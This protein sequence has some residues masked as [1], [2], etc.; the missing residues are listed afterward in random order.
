[1]TDFAPPPYVPPA[2]DANNN[3][4]PDI[5]EID[6]PAG[7]EAKMTPEGRPY[8][9]NH[10]TQSSTWED[11]RA[12]APPA[13]SADPNA[14][15]DGNGIPDR[16][17]TNLPEGWECRMQGNRPYWLNHNSHV[18]QW[19]D[20]RLNPLAGVVNNHTAA[21]FETSG[22]D[23]MPGGEAAGYQQKR[24]PEPISYNNNASAGGW[25]RQATQFTND[26][27]NYNW[28]LIAKW[29]C[30]A[31]G[32]ITLIVILIVNY[33]GSSNNNTSSR[34]SSRSSSRSSRGRRL[35]GIY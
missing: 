6:L 11:P 15:L 28:V 17:E 29:A 21:G 32:I 14:D 25:M 16:Y 9:I 19:E 13:Y 12:A 35:R 33:G 3:G 5:Y 7:Y 10:A 8:W 20:P 26:D 27:G 18:T 31:I 30:I 34:R 23:M 22:G 2:G 4:V 1:M 24:E